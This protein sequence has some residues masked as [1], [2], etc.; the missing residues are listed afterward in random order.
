MPSRPYHPSSGVLL[1]VAPIAYAGTV[2][3]RIGSIGTA[4]EG[5]ALLLPFEFFVPHTPTELLSEWSA[6]GMILVVAILLGTSIEEAH[7]AAKARAVAEVLA[8]SEEGFRLAFEN[9]M[10]GMTVA[11]LEGKIISANRAF[12]EMLGLER[13]ELIGSNFMEFTHPD[14]R[15]ISAQVNNRL[16]FGESDQQRYT[17]R[18]IHKDGSVISAEV[19]RSLARNKAGSPAFT[20]TSI[21]DITE[22]RTLAEQLSHQA[23]H[24]PLTGLPNRALFQDRL[25][26]A[27]QQRANRGGLVVLLL[28][29]LDDFKGVNDTLGHHVG[30]Q[31]LVSLARRL[32]ISTRSSDTWCRLGGDEFVY[33]AEGLSQVAQAHQV[34]ERVLSAFKEPFV[35]GD[36]RIALSA[37]IGVVVSDA[38]GDEIE[39]HLVEDADTA[40]YEAKKSGKNRITLFSP[41][42]RER[43]SSRFTLAQDLAYALSFFEISMHY[44]P[45]VNL[46]DGK[47]VGFESL[48]RWKHPDHGWVSP[49]VFIP[50]AEETDLIIR[51]GNFAIREAV[52]Q[53]KQ[54][55]KIDA[56]GAG[57]YVTVNLSAR[58]FHD[59]NLVSTVEEVLTSLDLAPGSLILEITESVALTDIDSAVRVIQR[60]KRLEVQVALD[61][62]GTGYS[63]LGYLTMLH[64]SIIKIDRSFV[65][66]EHRTDYTDRLLE[67]TVSLCHV[68]DMTVLAEGIETGDQLRLLHS[69]G[70]ELG[71]GYLFSPAT[72]PTEIPELPG[73]ILREWNAWST[74][75]KARTLPG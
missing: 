8:K 58:Q 14:D 26:R 35:I 54:W 11:D 3:G 61:D 55:E 52:K 6:F 33:L 4:I 73:R 71:Q 18:F 37:S 51:L 49:D 40:M 5:I 42:M 31:L 24:D 32:E 38:Q 57:A 16:M 21:R 46:A 62:F 36:S 2:F 9:N 17:K 29:D 41:E 28:L 20:I 65:S 72:A 70:C 59:P 19:S 67:A 66:P 74:N 45:I 27:I 64:P 44:Q 53:A 68:L 75:A 1:L 22:E 39:S 23:L 10:A 30:D 13:H 7:D 25:P 47:I 56:L 12:L 63:S 43:S 15:E 60:L 48:M 34:A 69:L 50:L